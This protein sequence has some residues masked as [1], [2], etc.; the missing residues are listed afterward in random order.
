MKKQGFFKWIC[1][2]LVCVL[3]IFAG[4]HFFSHS[5]KESSEETSNYISEKNLLSPVDLSKITEAK[6]ESSAAP[7]T[8]KP[9]DSPTAVMSEQSV[10]S[11]LQGPKSWGKRK[12]WSGEWGVTYYDGAKFG[13]FGCGLCCMANLYSSL[14][15]YQCTPIDAYY[16]AKE[17][18]KYRGG[19][20]IDW[21]YMKESLSSI[22]LSCE[23]QK[24]PASYPEFQKM[25]ASGKAAITLISSNES[26]I[27]WKDNPGHYVT[28]FLYDKETDKVFLSDSGVPEHNRQWISLKIIYQSLKTASTWQVLN[29]RDY[30]KQKD[31]W[32]HKTADGNWM[33]P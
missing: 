6:T 24:K 22:G 27:Y 3:L 11:F 26:K 8:E 31:R 33:K 10:F 15:P 23:L 18:T 28:I 7:V 16:Y 20:A 32:K 4:V 13:A 21:K 19:G 14:T 30:Q 25:I 1:G 29:V 5:Q 17:K 2:L 12:K 9:S